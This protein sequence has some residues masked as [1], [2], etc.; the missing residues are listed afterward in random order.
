VDG[1]L[2]STPELEKQL[3]IM[4]ALYDIS[5]NISSRLE[6]QQVFM[7]VVNRAAWLLN[8]KGSTLAICEPKTKLARVVALHNIPFE[9]EELVIK[10]GASVAGHVLATGEPVIINGLGGEG[11]A[12]SYNSLLSV[13][14][15][16]EGEVVG[17]LT[18]VERQEP[19]HF[20]ENDAQVLSL[21]A[22]LAA[23]A[24]NNANLY[25]K[26]VQLNSS[27][28]Q[29]V[30]ERTGELAAAQERLA[31]KAKQLQLLLGATIFLQEEERS[32][33]AGDLHDGPNQLLTGTLYEIQAA[34][35]AIKNNN[36]E[37]A[38]TSL[39]KAKGLLRE[40]ASENRRI[41]SGLRPPVLDVDGLIGAAETLAATFQQYSGAV[42]SIKTTGRP[43]RLEP[44]TET[45]VYRI[46]QEA[47]NNAAA[48]AGAHY[49]EI[50]INFQ[51]TLLWVEIIDDGIGFDDYKSADKD[52]MGLIGMK[53]RA[54]SLGGRLNI[55]SKSREGTKVVLEL[56]LPAL[57]PPQVRLRG[58]LG[59]PGSSSPLM[60]KGAD[61]QKTPSSDV[62]Q[63]RWMAMPTDGKRTGS[64]LQQE[65]FL[66]KSEEREG[67][68]SEV[69]GAVKNIQNDQALVL[70]KKGIKEGVAPIDILQK[71][72]LAGL[73]AI[74]KL[75]E[76]QHYFL[77]E[78]LMGAKLAEACIDILAPH[79]P[80]GGISKRGVVVMGAVQ[81]DLHSIGYG[82]VVHQLELA[83][84]EVHDLGINVPSIA[85]VD[86]AREVKADIIGLSAFLTSTLPY[87]EEVM[88]YLN[89]LGI[90]DQF[91]VVIGG[92]K[93]S[94]LL[95]DKIG[96]DGW[97]ADAV[98]A[99]RLCDD[100]MG[101]GTSVPR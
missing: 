38:L 93:T 50:V 49:V 99:A 75:F 21:L 35:K 62:E 88:N 78:L 32:Q 24:L 69:A 2:Y 98:K 96:A 85:F 58:F 5:V 44:H 95:A 55:T 12:E 8:A 25:S 74:G 46:I 20:T 40:I 33:I 41:S 13:P 100:L 9:Y 43:F 79:L 1:N 48:H 7:A 14:L 65:P 68:L 86:R 101:Y 53:E 89:D 3:E 59:Q 81:G 63:V 28:E 84:Y 18:V 76:S 61:Y 22:N 15:I 70:I 34:Q 54:K 11:A 83:G 73:K 39:E 30:E 29:K 92:A 91:K 66:N 94:R 23:T 97:A 6:I 36:G 72:I 4:R 52:R 64:D 80:K 57:P 10:P 45:T 82:L 42:C 19:G 67:F 47:L 71:G 60:V 27:L 90:R 26:V 87:L 37:N 16:W 56:P 77:G 31:R 17:A 51:D